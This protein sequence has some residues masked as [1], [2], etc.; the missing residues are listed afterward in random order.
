VQGMLGSGVQAFVE[1]G[2]GSVLLG[3]IRRIAQSSQGDST[4]SGYSLGAPEDFSVFE[5]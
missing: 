1:V 2:S 4:V 3:L 5:T